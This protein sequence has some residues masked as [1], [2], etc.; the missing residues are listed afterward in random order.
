M[1]YGVSTK[2]RETFF[3]G[4]IDAKGMAAAFLQAPS[5]RMNELIALQQRKEGLATTTPKLVSKGGAESEE[6]KGDR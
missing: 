5:S 4:D 3:F 2:E 1:K 6:V